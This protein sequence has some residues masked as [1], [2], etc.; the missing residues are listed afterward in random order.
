MNCGKKLFSM[1]YL[2]QKEVHMAALK[3]V[4]PSVC[5]DPKVWKKLCDLVLQPPT[6]EQLKKAEERVKKFKRVIKK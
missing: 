1:L 6:Q 2:W 5:D 3:P 4:Q